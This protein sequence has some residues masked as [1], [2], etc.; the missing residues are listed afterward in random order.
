MLVLGCGL[1]D[2]AQEDKA[3]CSKSQMMRGRIHH[4]ICVTTL[5]GLRHWLRTL[6]FNMTHGNAEHLHRG[7]LYSGTFQG[8]NQWGNGEH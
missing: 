8:I 5:M 1:T 4:S 3:T 6:A 2:E 7:S